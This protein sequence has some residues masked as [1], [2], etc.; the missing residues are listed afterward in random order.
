M[1]KL[2]PSR[3]A[4]PFREYFSTG[5]VFLAGLAHFPKHLSESMTQASAAATRAESVLSKPDVVTEGIVASVDA[6]MCSGCRKCVAACSYEAISFDEEAGVAV[7][8]RSLCKGCGACSAACSSGA[9]RLAGYK[10]EQII[11]QVKAACAGL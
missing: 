3:A 8:N 1:S 7:V 5:G 9:N 4:A 11:A 10:S 6:S 2:Y